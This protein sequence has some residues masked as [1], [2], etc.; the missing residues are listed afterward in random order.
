MKINLKAYTI[1]HS[2]ADFL[3]V[4]VVTTIYTGNSE[5]S[6]LA[7][8]TITVPAKNAE[9]IANLINEKL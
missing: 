1:P 4:V 8:E 3:T 6:Q 9:A 5:P 7:R 2:C